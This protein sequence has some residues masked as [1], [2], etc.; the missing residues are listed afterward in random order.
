MRINNID[1]P[2]K[3]G[4][5]GLTYKEN[6]DDIRESP[7]LQMIESM[8][9]H[10]NSFVCKVYDPWIVKDIVHNQV[11]SLDEFLDGLEMVIVMVGHSEIRECQDL[12]T[13][14]IVF[15]TRNV[16]ERQKNVYK[17]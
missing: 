1:D 4:I 9:N 10:L 2:S 16:F 7:T 6:V 3:V 14:K 8:D 12:F 13:D 15:D 5:Y 11:H 17:L